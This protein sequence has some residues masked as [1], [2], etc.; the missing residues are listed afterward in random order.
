MGRIGGL[1]VVGL[2]TAHAGIGCGSIINPVVT[3]DAIQRDMRSGKNVIVVMDR[4]GGRFPVRGRGMTGDAGCRDA[5]RIVVGIR[6][7]IVI[8]QVTPFTGVRR[9]G[10]IPLVTGKAIGCYGSVGAC[11]RINSVVIKG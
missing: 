3:G 1:V 2:M 7:G 11:K 9:G 6:R 5:D 4:E 10:V 8:R